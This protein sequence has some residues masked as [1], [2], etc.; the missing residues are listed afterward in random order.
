[1]VGKQLAEY[2]RTHS[3]MYAIRYYYLS[4]VPQAI[5]AESIKCGISENQWVRKVIEERLAELGYDNLELNRAEK[6]NIRK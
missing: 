3:K 2:V 5:E 4:G 1:M 6:L